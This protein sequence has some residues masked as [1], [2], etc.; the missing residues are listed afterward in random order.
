MAIVAR[1]PELA[2]ELGRQGP[3]MKP[4]RHCPQAFCKRVVLSEL[5]ESQAECRLATQIGGIFHRVPP[6]L[7]K[8]SPLVPRVP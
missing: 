7:I 8:Y 4:G 6:L 3:L 5:R 2:G 1:E